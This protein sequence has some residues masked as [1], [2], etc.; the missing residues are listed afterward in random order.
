MRFINF[1]RENNKELLDFNKT[2]YNLK[3]FD[4]YI[5]SNKVLQKTYYII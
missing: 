5:N 1:C 3:R 2:S 4:N